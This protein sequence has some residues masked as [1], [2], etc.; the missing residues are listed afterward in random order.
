MDVKSL[1][2]RDL[3]FMIQY[4]STIF[5]KNTFCHFPDKYEKYS[6]DLHTTNVA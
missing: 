6:F 3:E 2:K 1:K 4:A 5:S